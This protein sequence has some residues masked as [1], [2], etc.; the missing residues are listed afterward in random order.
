M[1]ND[2]YKRSLFLIFVIIVIVIIVSTLNKPTRPG[3]LGFPQRTLWGPNAMTVRSHD[4]AR[5]DSAKM[6]SMVCQGRL[7]ILCKFGCFFSSKNGPVKNEPQISP[8]TLFSTH[9]FKK[10]TEIHFCYLKLDQVGLALSTVA[11]CIGL[12]YQSVSISIPWL[13]RSNNIDFLNIINKLSQ[14]TSLR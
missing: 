1:F 11:N 3:S 2:C 6:L 4:W 13:H 12:S 5:K 9:P 14:S 7:R 10:L 8:W